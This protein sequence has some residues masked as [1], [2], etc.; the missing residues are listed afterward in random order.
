MTVTNLIPGDVYK[1]KALGFDDVFV[2]VGIGTDCGIF[3]GDWQ[4][5]EEKSPIFRVIVNQADLKKKWNKVGSREL[6]KGMDNYWPYSEREIGSN[7]MR[8]V[9]L[10]DLDNRISISID[11]FNELEPLAVWETEHLIGR[12]SELRMRGAIR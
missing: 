6:F 7:E 11:E 3:S 2:Q 1:L 12:I 4:G 5:F 9:T 8:K 10:D